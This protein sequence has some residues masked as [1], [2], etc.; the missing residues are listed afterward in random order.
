MLASVLCVDVMAL[1]FIYS[2]AQM[3][4]YP[5]HNLLSLNIACAG[6]QLEMIASSHQACAS[7][8]RKLQFCS[9]L[10]YL[11][12]RK[13]QWFCAL[14]LLQHTVTWVICLFF[15][16][17]VLQSQSLKTDDDMVASTLPETSKF[18][19]WF[20]DEGNLVS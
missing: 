8:S 9:P 1:Y 10:K 16:G 13:L 19:R 6:L 11:K 18:A 4:F 2:P 5:H 3:A 14:K 17:R 7:K 12:R 15:L 20:L